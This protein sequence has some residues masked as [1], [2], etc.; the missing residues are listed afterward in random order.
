MS[1]HIPEH[2]HRAQPSIC[3]ILLNQHAFSHN[4]SRLKTEKKPL[5]IQRIVMRP[6]GNHR[7]SPTV[8][9][10]QNCEE[11][12][13]VLTAGYKYEAIESQWGLKRECINRLD[14]RDRRHNESQSNYEA[15]VSPDFRNREILSLPGGTYLIHP[16]NR[17]LHWSERRGNGVR[18]VRI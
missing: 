2:K 16:C 10:A 12:K 9:W 4:S 3:F 18:D 1:R 7:P 17:S 8:K 11:K 6:V 14:G 13:A 15:A 5:M